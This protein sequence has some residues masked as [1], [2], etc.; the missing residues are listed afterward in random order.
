MLLFFFLSFVASAAVKQP[1]GDRGFGRS[2]AQTNATP[3]S[4]PGLLLLEDS[5]VAPGHCGDEVHAAMIREVGR[6]R[7]VLEAQAQGEA[8]PP[9][10]ASCQ[11]DA[12]GLLGWQLAQ[13]HQHEG[14]A[15]SSWDPAPG[16]DSGV[17]VALTGAEL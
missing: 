3:L 11:T 12:Q 17:L 16:T 1:W 13:L 15:S 6:M 9:G 14:Q 4:V 2:S 8:L 10:N 7:R 5:G